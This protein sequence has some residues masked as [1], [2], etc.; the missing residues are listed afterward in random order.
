MAVSPAL[1]RNWWKIAYGI[2]FLNGL[3]TLRLETVLLEN[4]LFIEWVNNHINE[5]IEGLPTVVGSQ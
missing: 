3:L 1:Q 4:I 5:Q 2:E